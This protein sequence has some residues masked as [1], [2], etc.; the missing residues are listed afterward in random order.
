MWDFKSG[1][2]SVKANLRLPAETTGFLLQ[3]KQHTAMPP[4]TAL[5]LLVIMGCCHYCTSICFYFSLCSLQST[6]TCYEK[7]PVAGAPVWCSLY[8]PLCLPH[9]LHTTCICQLPGPSLSSSL[10][11]CLCLTTTA[12]CGALC[13]LWHLIK[14]GQDLI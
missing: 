8:P 7:S 9:S 10:S 14:R 12:Q 4:L 1:P 5:P 11:R 3:K 2:A 13:L 6:P